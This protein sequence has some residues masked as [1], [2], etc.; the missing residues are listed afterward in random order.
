MSAAKTLRRLLEGPD[1]V[2]VPTCF[3]ALSARLG[4]NAGF[5]VAFMSGFG[6]AATR[7]GMP[8]AGLITFSEMVDQLRNICNAVPGLPVIGDGDTG[9]GNAMNLRRTVIDYARA[10]AACIMVEDQVTPK[11]CGHFEGKQVV[12]REEARMK[13][14]AAVEAGREADILVLA[15]TDARAV[16]GFEAALD[17]C[18]DFEAEGADII[19]LEAPLTEQELRDF[20]RAMKKP[21]MAN[22]APGGKTPMLSPA[23]LKEIGVKLAVYHPMLFSAVRAMRDSL[24]ALRSGNAEKAPPMATFDEVKHTVGLPEHDALERRYATQA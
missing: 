15:R 13:V 12:S 19:F 23:V 1:L 16:H 3:D 18:R 9:Y 20:V 8:D 14:R 5:P 7:L 11:R 21:T 22:L 2:T 24:E 6:V 10:G 4:Q 17:R